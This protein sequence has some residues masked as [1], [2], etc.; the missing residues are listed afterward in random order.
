LATNPKMTDI[1]DKSIK[2][3]NHDFSTNILLVENLKQN[4]D[5]LKR[6]FLEL[7]EE[8]KMRRKN[9]KEAETKINNLI[10]E[11]FELKKIKDE[12][13]VMLSTSCDELKQENLKL[14]K[15]LEKKTK[16]H[17]EE[18]N[19]QNMSISSTS[20]GIRSLKDEILSLQ[21]T[22]YSLQK[23][24]KDQDHQLQSECRARDD[25]SKQIEIF[26]KST[27]EY[28]QQCEGVS[29]RLHH[30]SKLDQSCSTSVSIQYQ[31]TLN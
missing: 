15:E 29:K 23:K 20:Q 31:K 4:Y 8:L 9:D 21:L 3:N 14:N 13:L 24:I 11:K 6:K 19:T 12:E 10:K 28:K 16:L 30:L 27:E 7:A 18:K 2:T 5:S 1:L 25:T 17:E 22:K 26:K